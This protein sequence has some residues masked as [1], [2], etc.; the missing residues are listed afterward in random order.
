MSAFCRSRA[1][2]ARPADP[3]PRRRVRALAPRARRRTPCGCLRRPA[4]PPG[5]GHRCRRRRRAPACRPLMDPGTTTDRRSA[6]TQ[7]AR[8]AHPSIVT[9]AESGRPR[10]RAAAPCVTLVTRALAQPEPLVEASQRRGSPPVEPAE[11]PHRGGHQ[12]RA[13]DGGVDEDRQRDTYAD[14]LDE[15]HAGRCKGPDDHDQQGSCTGDDAA[16]ALQPECDGA[17]V[18]VRTVPLLTYARE[19]E[20]LVVHGQPERD[21]EHQ[22]RLGGLDGAHGGEAEQPGQVALL[23]DPDHRTERCRQ[24]Q[25][26]HQHGL[27]GQDHRAEGQE[28]QE[29]HA[30]DDPQRGPG[31]R[32]PDRR[33]RVGVDG[34]EPTDEH[35]S[36]GR[37]LDG[38]DGLDQGS[39]RGRRGVRGVAQRDPRVVAHGSRDLGSRDA[40]DG[41]EPGL[42]RGKV[43]SR[44]PPAGR[45]R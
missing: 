44:P 35:P 33:E 7:I 27:D 3:P 20:H 38:A 10:G 26:V 17:G 31:Q 45:S 4:R 6:A 39:T 41:L 32:P 21:G 37:V 29:D 42:V 12:Q 15:G 34:A 30:S 13:H 5:T 36:A 2:V 14:H 9:Y 22:D 16:G 28:Q 1:A 11:Q 23:E 25:H 43:G 18:V 40:G 19:Q 8:G 24:A